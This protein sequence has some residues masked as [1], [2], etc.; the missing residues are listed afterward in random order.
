VTS[1]AVGKVICGLWVLLGGSC[2]HD[3]DQAERR[4][5]W[6]WEPGTQ[7][8]AE[9]QVR[10]YETSNSSDDPYTGTA[11]VSELRTGS[12]WTNTCMHES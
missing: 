12:C 7:D 6:S 8:P 2:G 10:R 3:E 11:A 5:T 1:P 4:G 9:D